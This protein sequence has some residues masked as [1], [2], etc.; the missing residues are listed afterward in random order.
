LGGIGRK[1][2]SHPDERGSERR[3]FAGKRIKYLKQGIGPAFFLTAVQITAKKRRARGCCRRILVVD[4]EVAASDDVW[5]GRTIPSE[6]EA[7][8]ALSVDIVRVADVH[9][10]GRVACEFSD[11]DAVDVTR[12]LTSCRSSPRDTWTAHSQRDRNRWT[13][14]RG[15]ECV[16]I[17]RE[18]PCCLSIEDL[19]EFVVFATRLVVD[20]GVTGKPA[21]IGSRAHRSFI[22]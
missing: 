1:A 19:S 17:S 6:A 13:D 15:R 11:A 18:C 9:H 4:N 2:L 20:F 21:R 7:V 14:A 3:G 22:H 10:P 12:S 16:C 5:R 8:T